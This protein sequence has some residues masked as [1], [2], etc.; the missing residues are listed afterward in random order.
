MRCPNCGTELPE[1]TVQCPSCGVMLQAPEQAYYGHGYTP[2][3]APLPKSSN[4]KAIIAIVVAAIV[5]VSAIAAVLLLGGGVGEKEMTYKEF[6]EQYDHD[7]DGSPESYTPKDFHEGDKVKIRD[8][9]VDVNY[10]ASYDVSL[11][12]C[13][14]T[15]SDPHA[16]MV[17]KGDFTLYKGK[18]FTYEYTFKKYTFG[19]ET[20]IM[21]EELWLMVASMEST[22][23]PPPQP[24]AFVAQ[25][26]GET[27][28][29]LQL[30]AHDIN[31]YSLAYSIQR[32]D[33]TYL[34]R[35]STFPVTANSPDG[36][37]VV[38]Y[39]LN[40]DDLIDTGDQIRINNDDVESGYIFKV[41]GAGEGSITLS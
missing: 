32:P 19:N 41:S 25:K 38:W 36:N 24:I 12:Q 35:N 33:G 39:D 29:T 21:P 28:W 13:K 14:S 18:E 40:G 31:P 1:G 37:G 9:A 27:N 6:L 20:Y 10:N 11:I 3:P 30:S 4:K 26:I 5:V 7:G 23:T 8:F 16:Y 2:Q 22:K 34:I 17:V 15:E